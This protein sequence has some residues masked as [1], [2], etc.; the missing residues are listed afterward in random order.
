VLC[1]LLL[2]SSAAR[3]Q[4]A[5]HRFEPTDLRLVDQGTSEIDVQAGVVTGD[6]LSRVYA[7]DFEASLG[8]SS[9][10]EIEVDGAFGLD[11]YKT[12][13]FADNTLIALRVAVLDL[14][15]AAASSGGWSAGFQGGPRLPSLPGA[16]GLGFEA[17]AIAGRSAG[18]VHIFA[19]GGTLIDS[20]MPDDA[21]RLVRPVGLEGGL[22]LDLDLDDVETWSLK[23]E[24]GGVKFLSPDRSQ[25]HATVGPSLW[26]TSTLEASAVAVVGILPG[27]DRLGL[28]LGAAAHF[29]AF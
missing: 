28:L 23:A 12:P 15:D 10:A 5:R 27:G 7:P 4:R 26:V 17:L 3:A 6:E 18:R 1:A 13:H 29:R 22:D 16:R 19:Q 2:A 24:L 11:D 14:R 8:I 21:G 25:L 9:H 20:A